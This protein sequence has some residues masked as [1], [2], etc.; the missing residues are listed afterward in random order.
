[1]GKPHVIDP[2]GAFDPALEDVVSRAVASVSDKG[3]QDHI[4]SFLLGQVEK[5]SQARAQADSG[6]SERDIQGLR[7]R[8]GLASAAVPPRRR[9]L[10]IDSQRP[11]TGRDA[12]SHAVMSH[13]QAFQTLGYEV[14]FVAADQ[15]TGDTSLKGASGVKMLTGPVYHSVEDVLRRQAGSF[16]VVYLHRAENATRYLALVRMHQKKARVVYNVADLHFLRLM[17]QAEV[18][19]RPEVLVRAQRMKLAEYASM[20]QADVVLTHSVTEAEQIRADVPQANVHVVP[21]SVPVRARVPGFAKRSGVVFLGN[22]AH[23]PNAD[24][25]RWLVEEIMPRVWKQDRSISCLLAGAE[26]SDSIHALARRGVETLGQVEDLAALFDSV[27]L[28]VAPLRFGAGIKGKVLDSFAAGVPCV[29]TP[30]AAE[31]LMLP[32][33]LSGLV[34]ESAEDLAQQIL[35]LHKWPAT[36]TSM[37]RAGRAFL[38]EGWTED[39]VQ[40]ALAAALQPVSHGM[41]VLVG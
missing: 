41:K 27:R 22:Y 13:M 40:Q 33:G 4:L 26:M 6:Q 25:A 5:L 29:M 39:L 8:R 11:D 19:Q 35:R 28:S 1:M 31:G 38:R 32:K 18:Q 37:S 10:M 15:M 17:R 23:A 30:V 7:K 3:D 9:V 16:D 12:G 34:R 21:W 20:L 2:V 14:S 36:H 24:A